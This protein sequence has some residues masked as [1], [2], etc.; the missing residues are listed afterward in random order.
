MTGSNFVAQPSKSLST[1]T[2]NLN[3]GLFLTIVPILFVFLTWSQENIVSHENFNIESY[4]HIMKYYY[5]SDISVV[6]PVPINST[7]TYT[8]QPGYFFESN[9]GLTSQKIKCQVSISPIF[10]QYS[11]KLDQYIIVKI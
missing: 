9:R 10:C 2:L 6:N 3:Y 8:C 7:I 11:K 5:Q 4:I 1:V